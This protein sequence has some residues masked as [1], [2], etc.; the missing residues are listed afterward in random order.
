MLEG[1]IIGSRL[2]LFKIFS[3]DLIPQSRMAVFVDG[4]VKIRKL[5]SRYQIYSN[6]EGAT[7]LQPFITPGNPQPE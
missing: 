1:I 5:G 4:R 7:P 3:S 2:I 6:S